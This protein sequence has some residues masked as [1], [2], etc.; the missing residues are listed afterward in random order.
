MNALISAIAQSE[1]NGI[2]EVFDGDAEVYE[3]V[4]RLVNTHDEL[5]PLPYQ[6]S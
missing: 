1:R 6:K 2:A 4:V 5:A 3:V